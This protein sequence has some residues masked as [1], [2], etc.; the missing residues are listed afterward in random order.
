QASPFV[1]LGV[2]FKVGS[3]SYPAPIIFANASQINAVVPS[4]LTVN[5]T[6]SVTVTSGTLASDGLFQVSVQ[7]ADPGIFTLS[8]QGT[9]QGAILN[10]DF[11]VNGPGNGA[12]AG[13][14]ISIYMTGL[15]APNSTA[16]DNAGNTGGFPAGC[17]AV[18]NTAANSPGY[19][20]VVNTTTKT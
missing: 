18:S 11:S 6:A 20:Q 16:I 3:T 7:A 12:A 4:G 15:G 5:G 10:Q 14:I 13:D 8:S 9:G 19:L 17:V 2:T 1:T